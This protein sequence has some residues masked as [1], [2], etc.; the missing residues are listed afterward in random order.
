MGQDGPRLL[1]DHATHPGPGKNLRWFGRLRIC[2]IVDNVQQQ[3]PAQQIA[4]RSSER[5]LLACEVPE[6][7]LVSA[8][9]YSWPDVVNRTGLERADPVPVR[10]PRA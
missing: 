8:P 6:N 4:E 10:P 2:A 5:V 1:A 7:F 3:K 9:E